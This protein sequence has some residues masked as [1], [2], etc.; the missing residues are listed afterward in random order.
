MF[1]REDRRLEHTLKDTNIQFVPMIFG[2]WNDI[3]HI[4]QLHVKKTDE[5]FSKSM[6]SV[7]F[8]FSSGAISCWLMEVLWYFVFKTMKICS[9]CTFS[10]I[11][12]WLRLLSSNLYNVPE[13]L[14]GPNYSIHRNQ[15]SSGRPE[16]PPILVRHIEAMNIRL[17][18]REANG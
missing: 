16:G 5:P 3:F 10:Y 14:N 2:L 15:S 8:S 1:T 9:S 7:F 4:S 11:P 18:S 12:F 6:F 13:A 17:T